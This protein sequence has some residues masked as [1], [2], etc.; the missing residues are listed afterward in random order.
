MVGGWAKAVRN[1][2]LRLAVT[3]HG[4]RAW[5]WYQAAQGADP[6][7]PLAGVPYDGLMTKE[8]GKGL[9]W[10]GLDPQDLYAQYHPLENT[11]GRRAKIRRWQNLL[12]K[13]F[14]P[15]D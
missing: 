14:Q 1:A 15:G 10:E 7:G 5:S 6:S 13:I 9:W 2:G 4:D 11:A 3:S 12:R 8:D